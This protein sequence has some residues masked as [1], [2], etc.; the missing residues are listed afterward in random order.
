MDAMG[1][2][3]DIKKKIGQKDIFKYNRNQ[4]IRCL[5]S[6]INASA[7]GSALGMRTDVTDGTIEQ[8]RAI[9]KFIF[10]YSSNDN[11]NCEDEEKL[12]H[13]LIDLIFYFNDKYT[14]VR[15]YLEQCT[16][17]MKELIFDRENNLYYEEKFNKLSSF[18]RIKDRLN[19]GGESGDS[20]AI[21]TFS[22][23]SYWKRNPKKNIFKDR[24][25]KSLMKDYMEACWL[26]SE[27]KFDYEF[28]DFKY[29]ELISFC[30]S[31]LLIGEYFF[32]NQ[33]TQTYGFLKEDELID[34]IRRLTDLPEEKVLF[35]LKYVSYDYEYQKDKLTLIQSLIK[36][37]DG[38]YFLPYNL[39]L[40]KLPI[41]M[42]RS[43]FDNDTLKYEK[44]ISAIA[45]LKEKQMTEEI[46]DLLKK[47]DCL[48]IKVGYQLKNKETNRFDAEYDILI[49]DNK[50]NK[51]Y[52]TECK[53]YYIGDGEFE[54]I[55]LEKKIEKAINQR[56]ERDKYIF[57]NPKEFVLDVFNK[58]EIVEV[59]E[60]LVSQNNM[61]MK[62]YGMTT[63][64]YDTLQLAIKLNDSFEEAMDYIYKEKYFESIYFEEVPHDIEIEGY[65]FRINK[66][67]GR[68]NY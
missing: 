54:H 50:T 40:G 43:I 19:E 25:Y 37:E 66:L 61:G 35:F 36:C 42:C 28:I 67:R 12:I 27:I 49:Y 18:S 48:D 56:L 33:M 58:K 22:M 26:D 44:D 5:I 65:K 1:I 62:K 41:K 15:N 23:V 11:P 57:D 32:L 30:A 59:K 31:L 29:S 45:K 4:L 9:L 68:K 60:F 3:Q 7:L 8:F 16:T 20:K 34:G 6:A 64:D 63:I 47:Y 51:L 38:Y 17:G 10:E 14:P 24:F 13:E 53:W 52:V 46:L 21:T 39:T 2:L 55:K